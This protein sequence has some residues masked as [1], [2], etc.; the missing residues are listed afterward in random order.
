MS[1]ELQGEVGR[2]HGVVFVDD[3]GN[4]IVPLPAST[5]PECKLTREDG[6][7]WDSHLILP[8][9]SVTRWHCP[10]DHTWIN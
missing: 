10:N 7:F 1:D 5:C 8:H 9:G 6:T 3:D 4:P 2:I